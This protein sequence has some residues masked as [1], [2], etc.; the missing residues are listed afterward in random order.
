MQDEPGN[1]FGD[2]VYFILVTVASDVRKAAVQLV[3]S[4]GSCMEI[5]PNYLQL[6]FRHFG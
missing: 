4:R 1:A 6:D 3:T 5:K 2:E